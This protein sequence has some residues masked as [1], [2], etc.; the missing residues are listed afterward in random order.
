MVWCSRSLILIVGVI[1]F[2]EGCTR[3]EYECPDYTVISMHADYEI[4]SYPQLTWVKTSQNS[5]SFRMATFTLFRRLY[6]YIS[7]NNDK[8]M[9]INMTVPVRTVMLKNDSDITYEMSFLIPKSLA[10]NPPIP[11]DSKVYIAKE[12]ATLYA[13]RSF[14]GYILKKSTWEKEAEALASS[15]AKDL[16]VDTSNYYMVGY[17]SPFTL[18]NR[19]NEIWMKKESRTI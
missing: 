16:S 9:K 17:D 5:D 1:W 14:S 15:V 18:M 2:S 7:R 19:L 13:V 10:D 3:K 8:D 4:R 12:N 6:K 11:K